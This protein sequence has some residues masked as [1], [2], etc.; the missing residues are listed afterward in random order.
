MDINR[1]IQEF[2]ILAPPFL[3]ALTVHEF[4]HGYVAHRLGDPTASLQGRL[5]LNPLKHLDLVGTIAFF[6]MRIGWAKPVPV[7]AR[8]FKNPQR[9][10]F[11][12]SLA[13]IGANLVTALISGIVGR[14]LR[15]TP[16]ILPF[17]I[18][19]P[20]LQMLGASVWINIMLAVFNLI[21][22]PP[23]DG[24]KVLMYFLPFEM[25]ASFAKLEP[26]GFV[27]LLLL[28]YSGVITKIIVPLIEFASIIIWG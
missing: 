15:L 13:G 1:L 4:S 16:D 3:M 18:L 14:L 2:T 5:T 6:I 24:S 17:F 19:Q 10:L 26:F 9:D 20:L 21:P 27:I 28:F 25:K 8:F 22:I 23:L 11:L 12:V 7:D